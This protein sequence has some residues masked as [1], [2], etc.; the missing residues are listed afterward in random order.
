MR[1]E[2]TWKS[3]LR[4]EGTWLL[5]IPSVGELLTVLVRQ[6]VGTGLEHF[7]DDVGALPWRR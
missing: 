5:D 4:V 3:F 1:N 6:L 7:D 2:K